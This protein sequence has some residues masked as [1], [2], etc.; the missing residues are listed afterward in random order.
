MD[1]R[2]Y[3]DERNVEYE[4]ITHRPSY[5]AQR[6]AQAIDESGHRVAKTVLLKSDDEYLLA[7]VPATHRIDLAGV[8]QLLRT[9]HLRLASEDETAEQFPDCEKGAVPPFG[10]LY[11]LTTLVEESFSETGTFAFETNTHDQAIRMRFSD[12]FELE[13]PVVTHLSDREP[14]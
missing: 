13:R 2:Q 12:F 6:L 7:V 8:T 10:S 3:L 14:V 4:V 5:D 11:G 1:I 9:D